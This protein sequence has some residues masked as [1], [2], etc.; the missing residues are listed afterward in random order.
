VAEWLGADVPAQCDGRAL[1]GFLRG[2][3]P[4]HWRDAA[5]FELDFRSMRLAVCRI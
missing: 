1:T 2:E 5:H 3:G 4:A